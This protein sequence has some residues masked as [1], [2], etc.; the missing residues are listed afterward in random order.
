[1][2]LKVFPFY[3][4]DKKL[5]FHLIFN[6]FLTND[7][8]EYYDWDSNLP[9][10][11]VKISNPKLFWYISRPNKMVSNHLEEL[12]WY[13]GHCLLEN[14]KSSF[15]FY[16]PAFYFNPEPS[17]NYVRHIIKNTKNADTTPGEIF[18]YESNPLRYYAL[19]KEFHKIRLFFKWQYL[20]KVYPITRDL[21]ELQLKNASL[22]SAYIDNYSNNNEFFIIKSEDKRMTFYILC[23]GNDPKLIFTNC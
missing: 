4:K 8:I 7:K 6:T 1:L 21:F 23:K 20:S 18:S 9:M 11:L 2:K 10:E 5:I 12:V 16:P 17:N 15:F 14:P 13:L 19:K 22:N 3:G